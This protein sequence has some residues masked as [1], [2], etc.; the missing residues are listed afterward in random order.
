MRV[1][2]YMK[3]MI[4]YYKGTNLIQIK[5]KIGRLWVLLV[6]PV[7]EGV[8]YVYATLTRTGDGQ[9]HSN[10]DLKTDK[11]KGHKENDVVRNERN[12]VTSGSL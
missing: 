9:E 11:N 1:H 5:C 2:T 4:D 7:D 3:Q 8:H 6:C 10:K 12:S